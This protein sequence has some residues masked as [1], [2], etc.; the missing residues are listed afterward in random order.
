MPTEIRVT[1]QK[2]LAKL[3]NGDD[4]TI[5]DTTDFAQHLKGGVLEEIKAVFNVQIAW[6]TK[7]NKYTYIYDATE[8]TLSIDSPSSLSLSIR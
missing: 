7:I 5:N 8:E 4:F 6:Y 1:N 2:F 3:N